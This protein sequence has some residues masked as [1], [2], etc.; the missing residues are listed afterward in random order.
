MFLSVCRVGGYA[1]LKGSTPVT[2]WLC[3]FPEIQFSQLQGIDV[4]ISDFKFLDLVGF[5]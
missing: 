2:K 1:V 5:K 3:T 4:I